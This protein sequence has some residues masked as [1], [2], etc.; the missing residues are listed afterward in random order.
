MRSNNNKAYIVLLEDSFDVISNYFL[1]DSY[2][3][4]LTVT[5]SS[6]DKIF[7]FFKEND[8]IWNESFLESF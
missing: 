7:S 2:M 3:S 8:P 1:V 6:N 4:L 5:S